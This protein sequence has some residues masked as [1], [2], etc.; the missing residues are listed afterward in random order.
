MQLMPACGC[1][2]HVAGSPSAH[3][4]LGLLRQKSAVQVISLG[5][6]KEKLISY[7]FEWIAWKSYG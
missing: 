6:T 3:Q 1:R 7:T 5:F 4:L 2:I